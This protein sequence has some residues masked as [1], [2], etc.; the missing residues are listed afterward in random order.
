M[1]L[2]EDFGIWWN[3]KKYPYNST[4]MCYFGDFGEEPETKNF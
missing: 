1:K 2:G 4:E 3:M